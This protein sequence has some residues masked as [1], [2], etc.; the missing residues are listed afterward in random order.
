MS[1]TQL[2]IEELLRGCGRRR[3]EDV[4]LVLECMAVACETAIKQLDPAALE[5]G[6][7]SYLEPGD[8]AFQA[9]REAFVAW[10][11]TAMPPVEMVEQVYPN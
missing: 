7:R 9:T 5:G 3:P 2:F 10:I 8:P 11:R 1:G 4:A 6:I